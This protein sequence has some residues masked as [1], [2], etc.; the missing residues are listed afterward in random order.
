MKASATQRKY[1]ISL[2]YS[3]WVLLSISLKCTCCACFYEPHC[4]MF[5]FTSTLSLSVLVFV[6]CHS[7][8]EKHLVWTGRLWGYGLFFLGH[9]NTQTYT[10]CA[11]WDWDYKK[12]KK[13]VSSQQDLITQRS[14]LLGHS[15]FQMSLLKPLLN[16]PPSSMLKRS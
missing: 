8:Q 12:V 13:S 9:T 6:V 2:S 15:L 1:P 4:T 16:T 5:C 3:C 7:L 14:P 10:S 11:H